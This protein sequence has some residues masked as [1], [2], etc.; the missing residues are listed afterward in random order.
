MPTS[1]RLLGFIAYRVHEAL[2][3]GGFQ[4]QG[5]K[6]VIRLLPHI[7][8]HWK[9]RQGKL[10]LWSPR[11]CPRT[12]LP[13]HGCQRLTLSAT[14]RTPDPDDI[15]QG[16]RGTC[17]EG[18]LQRKETDKRVTPNGLQDACTYGSHLNFSRWVRDLSLLFIYFFDHPT[19]ITEH[20]RGPEVPGTGVTALCEDWACS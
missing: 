18:L 11:S 4:H 20:P 5:I 1:G 13:S 8:K 9:K 14:S 19:N 10:W 15:L 3:G 7:Q 2:H 16:W 12:L 17:S 6:H